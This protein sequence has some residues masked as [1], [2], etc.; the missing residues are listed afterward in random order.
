MTRTRHNIAS[1]TL[2]DVAAAETQD[3]HPVLDTYARGVELMRELPANDPTSWLWAA[4]TH[5]I[6]PRTPARPAWGQCA[7]A[8]LFFLPWHRAYL[9]W[10]EGTIR[11]L[12]GDDAWG[13]PYW[14]YS[15]PDDP[16]AAF[17][18]AEFRASTRTVD[19]AV[20]DN[21]LFDPA[22]NDA[23][24]PADDSDLVPAL[25]ESR[26]VGGVP[27]VGFGGTDRDRRFGDVES[28]PHNWVHVDIAGLMESPATAGQDPIF[29]LHH[30]N[31]D[32]L[33][34][35]WL[36]LPGSLRLTDPGGASAFL[37]SQWQSAIFWFGSEQSPSTYTMED[38]E[39][40]TSVKM[41]YEYESIALPEVVA[42]AVAAA[43]PS[44][45]VG[46]GPMPLDEAE[47]RWEPVAATFNLDSEEER[48]VPFQTGPLG[49]DDEPPTRLVL[50]LAGV[51][52][53]QPHAAYVVEVRSAPDQPPHR[54]GRFAT[55]GLA[56]TAPEEERNYLVDA[57]AILPDLL[58][59]GWTGGQLSVKLV[60]E[61]G[62]PDSDD[63]NRA[64]HIQQLTVY[65]QTP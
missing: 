36:A 60:P 42:Q 32:R 37:V 47:A 1:L 10:F 48:E 12:T 19:G 24:I 54:A 55:F 59:E 27:D 41:D 15:D 22:R 49:L 44:A 63:P 17:L 61:E 57:S 5:G 13:L 31:I 43:R 21:T 3:W 4:N 25:S 8:S 2:G 16:D 6:P 18:P 34:E 46:G 14:D 9:A 23:P 28:T 53:E 30:A 11:A 33:W 29:W 51:R 50:E 64:I 65:T 7:H 52:A 26:Y 62:R 39:D 56:G 35:V 45:P 40:L 58:A 20:V 38:V